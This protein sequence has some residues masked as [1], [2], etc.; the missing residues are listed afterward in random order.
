VLPK[1]FENKR[2]SLKSLIKA[3]INY[4]HERF[5]T[6]LCL[7]RLLAMRVVATTDSAIAPAIEPAKIMPSAAL[8]KPVEAAFGNSAKMR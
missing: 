2:C 8:L 3:N 1:V 7:E 6:V 4:L 5:E